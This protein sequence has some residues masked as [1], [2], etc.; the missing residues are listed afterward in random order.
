[1]S[2]SLC[3]PAG[4][5]HSDLF[6]ATRSIGPGTQIIKGNDGR[7]LSFSCFPFGGETSLSDV[8]AIPLDHNIFWLLDHPT[9]KPADAYKLRPNCLECK[10][11]DRFFNRFLFFSLLRN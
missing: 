11:T 4:K 1:V 8:S 7:S 3:S 9:R 10:F 2:Q 5:R 6:S